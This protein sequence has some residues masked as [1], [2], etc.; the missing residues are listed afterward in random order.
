MPDVVI[1]SGNPL[2]AISIYDFKLPCPPDNMYSW[3]RYPKDH[4]YKGLSQGQVYV[5]ALKT[6][7]ALVTPRQ[8][9]QQRIH[10]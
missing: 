7:A 2:Q 8:G 3:R 10:P 5:E 9:V 4:T 1:H 6:D